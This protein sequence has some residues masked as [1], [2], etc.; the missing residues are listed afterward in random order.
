MPVLVILNPVAGRGRAEARWR[1]LRPLAA[2]LSPHLLEHRTAG[3]GDAARRVAEWARSPD[4]GPIIAVGGDGTVHEIVN[5]LH[6]AGA[7]VPVAVIPAGTGNDF[8]RNV[9]AASDPRAVMAG[10]GGPGRRCDLGRLELETPEGP[11]HTVVFANSASAGVS[12]TANRYAHRLKGLL[13]G[14][15]RYAA[16]GA[17]ALL[18]APRPA[19][20]MTTADGRVIQ[21]PLNV[22]LANGASFGGGMRIAPDAVPDDG[23]LDLV[24]IE[25]MPT[26]RALLALTRLYGGGHVRMRGVQSGRA[27]LP[28][29]LGV[30]AATLEIEADGQ[31]YLARG[32]VRV[33]ILPGALTV[34]G[35]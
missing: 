34:I 5:G 32:E 12:C 30:P 13:P 7:M 9:G 29:V 3:P 11:G 18:A 31:N 17:G 28:A 21:R 1:D 35:A 8:V 20:T 24:V 27:G 25:R 19:F 23:R 26:L 22:T 10:L 4:P 33:S 16:A 15:L 2:T 6:S 14:R